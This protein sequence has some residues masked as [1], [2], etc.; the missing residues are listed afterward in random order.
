MM[1]SHKFLCP[2]VGKYACYRV[3]LNIDLFILLMLGFVSCFIFLFEMFE[4]FEFLIIDM[5]VGTQI[6]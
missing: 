1:T 3:P 5:Y 4:C 2:I 6:N